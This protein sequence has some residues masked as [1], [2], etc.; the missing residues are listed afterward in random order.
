MN[1]IKN[2][3]SFYKKIINDSYQIKDKKNI[4]F[5]LKWLYVSKREILYNVGPIIKK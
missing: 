1:K 2:I 5:L 3:K 4:E